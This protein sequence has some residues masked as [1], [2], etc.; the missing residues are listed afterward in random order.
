MQGTKTKE[1]RESPSPQQS[2]PLCRTSGDVLESPAFRALLCECGLTSWNTL[3][4]QSHRQKMTQL[5]APLGTRQQGTSWAIGH[6]HRS[7]ANV[8]ATLCQDATVPAGWE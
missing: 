2:S 8:E 5:V 4:F 1:P 7:Q 3:T 6:A